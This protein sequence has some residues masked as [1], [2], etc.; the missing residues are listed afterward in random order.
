MKS[1]NKLNHQILEAVVPKSFCYE[2]IQET[3]RKMPSIE[4]VFMIIA[5][6]QPV[7]FKNFAKFSCGCL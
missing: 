2:T 7:T 5:L 6:L 3:C 1:F 4:V